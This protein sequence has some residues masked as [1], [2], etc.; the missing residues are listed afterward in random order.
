[1]K[2]YYQ[3]D[4]VTIYHGDCRE[5]MEWQKA[6]VLVTD[7]PYG[8]GWTVPKYNGGRAHD[9]IAN[10]SSTAA[11]DYIIDAERP[12]AAAEAHDDE[13]SERAA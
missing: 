6:G 13:T 12:L 11:R 10:D 3:D 2:P 5:V 9:G 7:P 8:I 1:M 4:A